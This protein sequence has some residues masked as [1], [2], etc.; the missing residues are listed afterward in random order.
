MNNA[1]DVFPPSTPLN[2]NPA[3]RAGTDS[4]GDPGLRGGRRDAVG[5]VTGA[6]WGSVLW[7]LEN[8]YAMAHGRPA[9]FERHVDSP[10][11]LAQ[12]EGWPEV[13]Q[14]AAALGLCKPGMQ[15]HDMPLAVTS[16]LLEHY[17]NEEMRR[18]PLSAVVV[19][20]RRRREQGTRAEPVGPPVPN[21][22]QGALGG[23]A[24]VAGGERRGAADAHVTTAEERVSRCLAA[25]PSASV[26]G[27]MEGTGLT[28]QRVW[29]TPAWQDHEEAALA[30]YLSNHPH[31]TAAEAA[32]ALHC[33]GSK[34]VDMRAWESHHAQ[35]E[36]AKPPRR[37]KERPLSRGILE[38]RADAGAA[39]P[40]A[41]P[42]ARD[43]ISRRLLEGADPDT[44]G[45]LNRL[46]SI[47]WEALLHHLVKLGCADLPG[48]RAE[49][50]RSILVEAALSWLE[51]REQ[52]VR[53]QTRKKGGLPD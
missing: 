25:D 7:L 26:E 50:Q 24:S 29:R 27:V 20:L 8:P 41:A 11:L 16:L 39:D 32:A 28:K 36:A 38:R 52:E 21:G 44:R 47:G 5:A 1:S 23:A 42:E 43:E 46:N 9:R 4:L 10:P 12:F 35:K 48:Y 40:T 17:S 34:I 18:L 51:S 31:A 53:H 15:H 49:E 30:V 45:R 19:F 37:V 6:T 3:P 22:D 33:S 14:A 2:Q 13:W